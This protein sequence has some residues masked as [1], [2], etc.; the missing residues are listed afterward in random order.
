MRARAAGLALLVLLVPAPA[1]AGPDDPSTDVAA[2]TAKARAALPEPLED[3]GLA[4]EWK[5]DLALVG[6]SAGTVTLSVDVGEHGGKPVW[7]VSEETRQEWGGG[8]VAT[9]WSLYLARD[10]SVLRGEATRDEGDRRV[11]LAFVRDEEKPT[12]FRVTREVVRP[13]AGEDAPAPPAE[14]P[15]VLSVPAAEGATFG[16]AA[17]VLFLR[18]APK[19]KGRYALPAAPLSTAWP[20]VEEHAP[21]PD[22]SIRVEVR[23]PGTYRT[24]SGSR[25]SVV[26]A[27]EH[28]RERAEVHLSPRDRSLLG[29]DFAVPPGKRWLPKGEAG[30]RVAY[31]DDAPATTWRAAFLKFGHGYHMAVR[32]WLEACAHWPSVRAHDVAAGSWAEGAGGPDAVRDAYVAEWL[33]RSKHRGR[34]E[35]D[36]LLAMT[37]E[38]GV[39]SKMLDGTV[40]LKTHP[41]FGGNV[42]RFRPVDGVWY[43]VGVD[44]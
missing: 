4:F 5:G 3:K 9:S 41:E 44:Q 29:V 8:V 12:A 36:W 40:V 14:P 17:V 1:S 6:E 7:L 22:P 39:E 42:F 26:A 16:H 21:L 27:L 11:H 2:A 28:M 23:G 25:E 37:L 30:P 19:G 32:R 43:I 20:T 34:A 31:A 18:H 10:L 15:A 13:P 24:R 33:A 38:T 35:A